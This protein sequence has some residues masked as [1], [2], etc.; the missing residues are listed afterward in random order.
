MTVYLYDVLG[1]L[2]SGICH[3][4]VLFT[5]ECNK[6]YMPVCSRCTGIYLGFLFSLVILLLIERRIKSEVP[7]TKVLVSIAATVLFIGLDI[8]LTSYGIVEPNNFIRFITG[9][10][11]GWGFALIIL[12]LSNSVMWQKAIKR[13]YLE[14]KINISIWLIAG[15]VVSF[16]FI[17]SYKS[18]LTLW[19]FFSILGLML[20]Y[21]FIFL[22]LLFTFL[23]KISN[24]IKSKG[25]YII[26]L[27]YG[28]LSS[29]AFLAVSATLR[30]FILK[31]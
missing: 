7:S 14:K 31:L 16:L 11:V 8:F 1:F 23:R 27:F 24:S 28:S 22:I 13:Q 29:T 25:K 10:I 21:A 5:F 4:K 20:F 26:Y 2:G 12:P 30:K 19:G 3:Q 15:A 6:V 18:F 9:F 17:I